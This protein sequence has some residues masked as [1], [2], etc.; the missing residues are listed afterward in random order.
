MRASKLEQIEYEKESSIHEIVGIVQRHGELTPMDSDNFIPI[1]K[2]KKPII[3]KTKDGYVTAVDSIEDVIALLYVSDEEELL[4]IN[5]NEMYAEHVAQIHDALVEQFESSENNVDE[6]THISI[7]SYHVLTN[8]QYC[9]VG[10]FYADSLEEILATIIIRDEKLDEEI[11]TD[12]DKFMDFTLDYANYLYE[13]KV[14]VL[15]G[16]TYERVKIKFSEDV[17][18]EKLL[19]YYNKHIIH[20]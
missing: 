15:D 4:P 13:P 8:F 12:V 18:A 16:L 17:D 9:C 3:L 20:N 5:L 7:K 10:D 6:V 2:P 11:K 14:I 1:L 19:N